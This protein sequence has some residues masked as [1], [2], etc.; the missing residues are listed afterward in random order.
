MPHFRLEFS[1]SVVRNVSYHYTLWKF[2]NAAI[3]S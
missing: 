3:V 2:S 1:T